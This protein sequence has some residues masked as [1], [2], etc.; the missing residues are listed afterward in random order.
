MMKKIT[1]IIL[2][3]VSFVRSQSPTVGLLFSDNQV[4]EGYTLFTPE[5]NQS[6][7]LINNCGEKVNEWTFTELPGA[8]CYLLENG[9]L[10]RAGKKALEIRDWDNNVLWSYEMRSNGLNQHHDIEPL[11]NGNILCI[12]RDSYSN[13][14]IIANGKDPLKVGGTIDLD[15]IVELKPIGTNDA[16]IVWEWKFI[17]HLIQ[18]YD[19]TKS[20]FGS[21]ENHPELIDIN[22]VDPYFEN[23][24]RG[25]TH[26]NGIDYNSSL[27]QII[28][29]ARHLNEIYIIDHSTT[30]AEAS[31]HTGG[32]SNRGGDILW[33]W[34]NPMVYR[35]GG[36]KD[37]KLF[38]QHDA[39]WVESG[40][41]DEGKISVFNN[42]GDGIRSYSSVHLLDP[43][44]SSN[45]YTKVNNKFKPLDFDWSWTGSILG[46]TIY[47]TKKSG[48]HSLPNGNFI[49]CETSLGQVSE[50][51][52][53]GEHL[54]TY[55][56]PSGKNTF[57]QF[58]AVSPNSNSIFRAEKYPSYY[59]GFS[60][61]DLTPKG[62][63]ENENSLSD[64][65]ATLSIATSEI[66]N[67]KILNPVHNNI[68]KFNKEIK[69]DAIKIIDVNGRVVF[70]TKN[71]LN[72]HIFININS[73]F[74]FIELLKGGVIKR[75]K[76]IIN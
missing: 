9:T 66:D 49:I 6:V 50:I 60:G 63:I 62:I 64:T 39:K 61:K 29:S 14:E 75:I 11:P 31:G 59:I 73:G 68:L 42:G 43:E 69:L 21:V 47:E 74:Y 3:T 72:D 53:T 10:L 54:W 56:N 46:R 37:Q 1:F 19:D 28:I 22:Y 8:T 48:T 17:D 26:V 32:N 5:V 67:L 20:N 7:Y 13:S 55:K 24:D 12:V 35:Q 25:Y 23:F 38:L 52:K 33:R 15:K 18:D 51:T 76:I 30:L 4:T 2:L 41:L 70:T 36:V 65:C 27:D 16:E 45:T 44:I 58:D 40:Y 57:N 34:G 71:F